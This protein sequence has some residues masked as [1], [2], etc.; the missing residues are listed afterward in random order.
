MYT[1]KLNKWH[2]EFFFEFLP[3][4]ECGYVFAVKLLAERRSFLL[5]L[6][7]IPPT[8]SIIQMNSA[9]LVWSSG[10]YRH[11]FFLSRCCPAGSPCFS[12]RYGTVWFLRPFFYNSLLLFFYSGMKQFWSSSFAWFF[13]S[14]PD[15][16][17]RLWTLQPAVMLAQKCLGVHAT[18]H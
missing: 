8:R 4:A 14:I 18:M 6:Y 1:K 11:S 3:T 7:T 9:R 12:K 17:A 10:H 16:D 15:T 13:R 5:H 2:H